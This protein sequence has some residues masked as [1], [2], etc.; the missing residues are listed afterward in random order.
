MAVGLPLKT[1]YLTGDVYQA[2]DVNDTN[3]TVNLIGQ[4]NNFY[5]GKNKIIN[6]DMG[7]WQR[8]TTFTNTA[9]AAYTADRWRYS[10]DATSSATI[11]QQTFTPG[12]APVAGYEGNFFLRHTMTT[13]GTTT[14]AQVFQPVEDVRT[15]AGQTVTFSFWAKADAARSSFI[16]AEQ[17]FGTGGS[18]TVQYLS[19]GSASLTTSWQRFSFTVALSSLAG[20]TIGTSSFLNFYIR[21]G[22]TLNAVTDIWG[23][24]LESGSTATAF[25]TATGSIE[26]ELAACQRYYVRYTCESGA[27]FAI[28]APS[29][30]SE[31]STS[32][33]CFTTL[34]VQ[35]RVYPKAVEYGGTISIT[36]PSTFQ[37]VTSI[38]I[39]DRSNTKIISITYNVAS[40]LTTGQ[41]A[42]VRANNSSTAFLGISAEF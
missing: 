31:S 25:Q 30:L 36:T 2:S 34:P 7:V 14:F 8:G 9:N 5:A 19:M 28:F 38:A 40:G 29:G 32:A 27:P 15:F 12:T 13:P 21:V 23:V 41:F 18:S 33:V 10:F 6:G 3:G 26:G 4:T 1:T 24:Q 20:K 42:T 37:N 17:N 11:S 16:Y 39:Q 22:L 35:L